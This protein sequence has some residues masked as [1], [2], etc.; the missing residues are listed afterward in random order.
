M[1][2]SFTVNLNRDTYDLLKDV[3]ASLTLSLGF[4]PTL[5]Q[6]VRHL[7]AVFQDKE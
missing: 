3:Q 1:N 2:Q 4:E 5:G 7:I 6:V